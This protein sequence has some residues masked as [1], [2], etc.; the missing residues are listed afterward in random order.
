MSHEPS[1]FSCALAYMYFEQDAIMDMPVLSS[2]VQLRPEHAAPVADCKM[3]G[4]QR[5]GQNCQ[6]LRLPV[7]QNLLVRESLHATR[8]GIQ[9]QLQCQ[10]QL[11]QTELTQYV[12]Q[13][14]LRFCLQLTI[15]RLITAA[16][17]PFF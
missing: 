16:G 6:H 13:G 14:M 1:H 12:S 3:H 17:S 10:Q 5:Q 2:S 9:C 8:R 7:L 15:M 4:Q 11:P